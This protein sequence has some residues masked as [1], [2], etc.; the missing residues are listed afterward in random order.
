MSLGIREANNGIG[1]PVW[2]PIGKRAAPGRGG[3]FFST[4]RFSRPSPSRRHISSSIEET[5]VSADRHLHGYAGSPVATARSTGPRSRCAVV[6]QPG[7][8][9]VQ[10][11]EVVRLAVR[12]VKATQMNEDPQFDLASR[13]D[14]M[15]ND[16]DDEAACAMSD[17]DREA[18]R[19]GPVN[20]PYSV[21]QKNRALIATFRRTSMEIAGIVSC[22]EHLD[23]SEKLSQLIGGAQQLADRLAE[24]A[25]NNYS[26]VA[27]GASDREFFNRPEGTS[28]TT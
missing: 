10:R 21:G 20:S 22:A 24:L 6:L 14:A 4:S 15:I 28:T 26:E 8:E 19:I 27:R 5:S 13:I 12:Q 7:R 3:A 9:S 1:K 23:A 11:H 16:A 17:A 2:D 18:S 25:R